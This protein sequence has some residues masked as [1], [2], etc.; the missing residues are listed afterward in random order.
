MDLS[1]SCSHSKRLENQEIADFEPI[2]NSMQFSE[3]PKKT[4]ENSPMMT[5]GVE[6]TPID[7]RK[8]I[9]MDF[10]VCSGEILDR[11]HFC[12]ELLQQI[13]TFWHQLRQKR[14]IMLKRCSHC[15]ELYSFMDASVYLGNL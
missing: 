3:R 8:M 5:F 2:Q 6:T 1:D 13:N 15:P 14:I 7:Q 11:V 9:I 10:F 4:P 12:V